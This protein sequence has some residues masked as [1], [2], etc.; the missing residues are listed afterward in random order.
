M[1]R[2]SIDPAVQELTGKDGGL[3]Q[4][5]AIEAG[6]K[7]KSV[8]FTFMRDPQGTAASMGAARP[9]EGARTVAEGN[10]VSLLF[11]LSIVHDCA[12]M[13]TQE[14]TKGAPWKPGLA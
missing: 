13:C 7:M 4:W 14:H 12:I 9:P 1:Q 5:E 6:R 11:L 3:I 2:R 8:R 10:P